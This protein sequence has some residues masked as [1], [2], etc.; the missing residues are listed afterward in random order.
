MFKVL[1]RETKSWR[2]QACGMHYLRER[3]ARCPVCASEHEIIRS[4]VSGPVR[5]TEI[6]RRQYQSEKRKRLRERRKAREAMSAAR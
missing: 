3:H 6:E 4:E 5:Q 1:T 2:L